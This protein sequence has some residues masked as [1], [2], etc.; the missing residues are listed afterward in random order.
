MA[1]QTFR[2][3]D[4]RADSAARIPHAAV[5][6]AII[7]KTGE[8]W[9]V[10]RNCDGLRRAEAITAMELDLGVQRP[11]GLRPCKLCAV[12]GLDSEG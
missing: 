8:C 11:A 10:A 3:A 6:R 12:P 1:E 2:L 9:H 4:A 7:T 5:Y